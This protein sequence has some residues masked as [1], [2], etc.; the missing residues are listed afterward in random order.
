MRDSRGRRNADARECGIGAAAW[1]GP[2]SRP[3]RQTILPP[4]RHGADPPPSRSVEP[5]KPA[6]LQPHPPE[7]PI[8]EETGSPRSADGAES[9]ARSP[10]GVFDSGL[11]GL[12][13]VRALAGRLPS[14][15][16][17]YF[18]DTARVPY[19]SKSPEAVRH[20]SRQ[21]GRFL[22]DRGVKSIVVACNTATAHALEELRALA[23]VRVVGVIEAG[24][25]AAVETTR[26]GRIGVIGTTG[27]IRSGAYDRAVRK[28]LSDVEVYAQACPLFVPMVEEGMTD[29]EA[30]RMVAREYLAP[31][32]DVELDTLILGC[33]HYPLLKDLLA[34]I[35][36]PEIHLID[37][38]EETAREVASN[39]EADGLLEPGPPTPRYHFTASD[40]PIQFRNVGRRFVPELIGKV[41]RVDVEAYG[42]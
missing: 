21:A 14:E 8:P 1:P 36:G 41:E 29:H 42:E 17:L 9:D 35:L 30:T 16:I 5:R 39:L 37:S 34:E 25:R 33:T 32:R 22:L 4:P 20:F 12:T 18:G 23:P 2:C 31:L 15:S 13:V 24:A 6:T 26:T 38:A 7:G 28:L 19:G 27:T 11:G 3:F 40:L 10:V